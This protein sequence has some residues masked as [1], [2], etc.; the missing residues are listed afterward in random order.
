MTDLSCGGQ[1]PPSNDTLQ[2]LAGWLAA[3]DID[4]LDMGGPGWAVRVARTPSGVLSTTPSNV[5]LTY[6]IEFNGVPAPVPGQGP[7]KTVTVV[8][9]CAGIF[10]HQ[11]PWGGG[12]VAGPGEWVRQGDGLGFLQMGLVL[13]PVLASHAG[14]VERALLPAG[15]VAGYGTPLVEI[16]TGEA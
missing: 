5:P 10:L 3:A 13:A 16:L 14:V 8:A 2:E 6:R 12:G 9:P 4:V 15:A 1:T 11:H 7:S